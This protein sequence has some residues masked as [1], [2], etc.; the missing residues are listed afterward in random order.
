MLE[1]SRSLYLCN[2]C[3]ESIHIW[4][5]GTLPKHNPPHTTLPYPNP[6][7]TPTTPT[8]TLPLP[9]PYL[10]LPY[11]TLPYPTL[12]Y[13]TLPYPTLPYPTLTIPHPPHPTQPYPY[14]LRI[15]THAHK[16]ASCSQATLSFESSY[17]ICENKGIDQLCSNC[18][19][20]QHLCFGYIAR[21]IPLLPQSK[22]SS[23]WP[24][25]IFVQLSLC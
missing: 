25:S 12:P 5:K 16:Q 17:C 14:P 1:F 18:T 23:L 20:D 6:Y 19:A 11:P 9:Y 24:S 2:H 8:L 4:T 3:S 22:I 15:Q 7:P 21:I 10:T 13:P